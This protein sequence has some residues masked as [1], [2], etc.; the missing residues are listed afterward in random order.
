MLKYESTKQRE[1]LLSEDKNYLK[2]Q[3][4]ELSARKG[5]LEKMNSD[6]MDRNLRL[7]AAR[8]ELVEKYLVGADQV[9]LSYTPP[10]FFPC[11]I[12]KFFFS[13]LQNLGEKLR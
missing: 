3:N 9:H 6:L 11:S 13:K 12:S 10:H 2:R 1:E 7:Q 5:D 4:T 8:E